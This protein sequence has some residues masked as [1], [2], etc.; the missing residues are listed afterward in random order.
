MV[1][2]ILF[3]KGLPWFIHLDE[4][5]SFEIPKY[6]PAYISRI[7]PMRAKKKKP[8]SEDTVQVNMVKSCLNPCR[9]GDRFKKWGIQEVMC[10]LKHV[11]HQG[12]KPTLCSQQRTAYPTH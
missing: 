11:S 8:K 4:V 1:T 9:S 6:D 2:L 3:C 12:K 7:C 10:H 5:V